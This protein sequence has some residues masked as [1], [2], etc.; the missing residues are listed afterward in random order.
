MKKNQTMTKFGIIVNKIF[1][2][3]L[4]KRKGNNFEK[5]QKMKEI[6]IKILKT[7]KKT[8]K[9]LKKNKIKK[10]KIQNIKTKKF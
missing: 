2:K 3:K 1:F 5:I 6:E 9:K 8:T 4:E 7:Y 10:N